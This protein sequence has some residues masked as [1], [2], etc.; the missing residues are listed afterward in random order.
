MRLT[1][2]VLEGA[3]VLR[4]QDTWIEVETAV[5]LTSACQD[6][7][8]FGASTRAAAP[9]IRLEKV[10]PHKYETRNTPLDSLPQV[11]RLLVYN[12]IRCI[13]ALILIDFR[14]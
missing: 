1:C 10:H 13:I 7:L 4:S 6:P 12:R 3:G 5:N 2:G 14:V 8:K 9:L 11:L